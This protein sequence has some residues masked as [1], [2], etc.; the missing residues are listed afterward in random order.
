M[1]KTPKFATC[2]TA[3]GTAIK[4]ATT[5]DNDFV[6]QTGSVVFVQFDY[7]TATV[8]D[9]K[10][11]VDNTGSKLIKAYGSTKPSLWWR[12]GDIV[13]FVY[14]GTY[15]IMQPTSGQIIGINSEVAKLKGELLYESNVPITPDKGWKDIIDFSVLESYSR[16]LV[17]VGIGM[18]S[19]QIG[20]EELTYADLQYMKLASNAVYHFINGGYMNSTWYGVQFALRYNSS[21]Q[22]FAIICILGGYTGWAINYIRIVGIG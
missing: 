21:T 1:A 9:P 8:T 7:I 18:G 2:N 15:W 5:L 11:D 6:L 4:V 10:L 14:D 13:E 17:T 3:S 12:A 20:S 19:V 22:K 16:I